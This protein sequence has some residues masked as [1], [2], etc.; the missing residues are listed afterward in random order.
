MKEML[1]AMFAVR[2]AIGPRIFG[3]EEMRK[4]RKEKYE[5]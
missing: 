3:K 4:I 2:V 5:E 1:C